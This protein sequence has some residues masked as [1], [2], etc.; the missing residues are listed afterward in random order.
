MALRNIDPHF[1]LATHRRGNLRIEQ[2]SDCNRHCAQ[3]Q[4]RA[5]LHRVES[6]QQQRVL[7]TVI[8]VLNGD[9]VEAM[10]RQCTNVDPFPRPPGGI[11]K[12]KPHGWVAGYQRPDCTS[13]ALHP[14]RH[15]TAIASICRD[16]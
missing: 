11:R 12:Q 7:S 8:I 15:G 14:A 6:I 16:R 10:T 2:A 1:A 3:L 4:R 5:D 9:S 13:R